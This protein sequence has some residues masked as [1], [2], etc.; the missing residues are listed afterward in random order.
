MRLRMCIWRSWICGVICLLAANPV[1]MNAQTEWGKTGLD[2]LWQG[3]RDKQPAAEIP[4]GKAPFQQPSRVVKKNIPTRLVPV[5]SN[6]WIISDGWELGTS[7]QVLESNESIFSTKF[8]T[9][10]WYNAT[11]P[12]TVLTTLVNQGVYPEPTFGL[13]N[14]AIPDTL[15]RMDW[16]YR[17][18]F[19]YPSD[20]QGNRVRLLFN[21]INYRAEVFL[22]GKKLGNINGAFIRG[23]YDITSLIR[24]K[25]N[26]LAVLIHPP[27][28]PGIPHEQSM[29]AGQGLNGGQLSLDGPTF[30]ASMGWDW[31]PGIRDRNI[32][33]W[34]D[35]RLQVGGDVRIGDPHVIADL[36]LPDTTRA[37]V[38]ICVPLKN[39][40][41]RPVSGTVEATFDGTTIR[42]PYTLN[43]NE[44]KDI[45]LEP[46]QHAALQMRN[47]KLWWPNGYGAQHLYDLSLQAKVGDAVSDRKQ[48]RFGIRELSYELMIHTEEK[49]NHRVLYTPV[50][51]GNGGKPVFNYEKVAIV[52]EPRLREAIPTLQ[53]GVDADA[54][55]EPLSNDDPVG[56]YLVFRVNGRR[57]FI[58][59][60][61]WGMD[62]MM[63]RLS[64][65]KMELF[66][67]LEKAANFNMIRNW[68]GENTEELFYE[69]ADEYGLLVWNDFWIT[70]DDTVDPNDHQLFLQNATDV[71]RRF[72]VHPSIAI[73]CPRNE[74]YAPKGLEE[75]LNSMVVREDPSRHYH[76]NS[77]HLNMVNSGPY[78]YIKDESDYFTKYARGFNTELGAQAIPTAA[79]I[80]KFIAPEDLWPINDVW[81]YHDLHHKS[82]FF[83]D[84]IAAVNSYGTAT[85][86][87]D[88]AKKGQL[89]SYN[90]WRSIIEAVNSKMWG[91]TTG[92]VLW[93]SHPSWP[94]MT[95]QTHTYDYETPG[96]YF[97]VKK[98]QEPVH[99]Q[100]NPHDHQVI[101][102]NNTSV[103]QK[104][105]TVTVKGYNIEG[106]LYYQQTARFDV[107]GGQKT[108]CFRA[109]IERDA[110]DFALIRLELKNRK[111]EVVSVND[112]WKNWG[113]LEAN[114]TINQLSAVT[115]KYTIRAG[116]NGQ[117]IVEITNPGRTIA[118]SV[119]LNACCKQTKELIL[120]AFFSEGYFNLL[121]GEK[122][123]VILTLP[124]NAPAF[125]VMVSGYN[126]QNNF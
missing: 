122:R 27:Y 70:T 48:L 35:V 42:M 11:V 32:G 97:G 120:P 86:V 6:E 17:T 19:D 61:T 2:V 69:L 110:P 114:Q 34:Q 37:A 113:R 94:S 36:P 30:I 31:I 46:E 20:A 40:T 60:A 29:E 78:G 72:R 117:S 80:R 101:I 89:V 56:Q 126:I 103:L 8:N 65:E 41:G 4:V 68:T 1:V 39:N 125:D 111:G 112:Y 64:R 95:W 9:H 51:A 100:L 33:L 92:L 10:D 76:G 123:K 3:I 109:E 50:D 52:G 71:V 96:A 16:W 5:Q 7:V 74:G 24:E 12:G 115:L 84:F 58:K 13:N 38:T 75:L 73:W 88:F 77:R 119:K 93:M 82:H 45:T 121:P 18:V 107:P 28:N 59:G 15:C 87:D 106:K 85:G 90:T 81:A 23:E 118:A 55:F 66:F 26:V 47:P 53:E 124:D 54:L 83:G 62:E 108:D 98:A 44:E 22:N 102:L 116:K 79:T 104:G 49:G 105:M 43:A 91:N 67:Q 14:M 99:V 25:E 21:G 63:K 57:I